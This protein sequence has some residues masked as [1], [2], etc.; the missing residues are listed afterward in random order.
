MN[1]IKVLCGID[2]EDGREEIYLYFDKNFSKTSLSL[3]GPVDV[4]HNF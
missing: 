2:N 4:A 1:C 3:L